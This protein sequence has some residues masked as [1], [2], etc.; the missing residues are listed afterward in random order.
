MLDSHASVGHV[1][2]LKRNLRNLR[3][4]I[5]LPRVRGS[6]RY[7][8]P[9]LIRVNSLRSRQMPCGGGCIRGSIVLCYF[10]ESAVRLTL[11]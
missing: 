10:R 2:I 3:I 4:T 7:F 1:R 5:R 6:E 8:C 11:L 9:H